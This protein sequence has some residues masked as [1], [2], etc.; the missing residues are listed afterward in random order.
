MSSRLNHPVVTALV[1]AVCTFFFL[2]LTLNQRNP[3]AFPH[4]GEQF[5]DATQTP[6]NLIVLTDSAGYDGQYYYRLALKPFTH[7]RTD[8]GIQID[9]PRYRQQRILYPLLAWIVSFGSPSLATYALILVNFLAL[10]WLGYSAGQF[11]NLAGRQALWGL[12]FSLYP[13]FLLTQSR[14]LAEIVEAAFVLAGIVALHQ[15]RHTVAAAALSLAILAKETALLTA[16][17]II[18]QRKYWKIAILP[19]A[20]YGLWQ[21]FMN[22]WWGTLLGS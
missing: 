22:W 1:T 10:I 20:V 19:L 5:T 17:S 3:G 8:F 9:N 18:T 21:L 7:T 4:A 6:A 12:A 11:A 13:G 2:M 16:V 14:D 15:K